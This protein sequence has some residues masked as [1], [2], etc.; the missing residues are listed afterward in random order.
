MP[1]GRKEKTVRF[2]EK[3]SILKKKYIVFLLIYF[4][5]FSLYFTSTTMSKYVT[6]EVITSNSLQVA[7]WDVDADSSSDKNIVLVSGDEVTNKQSYFIE[8]TSNSE[9]AAD[10]KI[11]ISNLKE[12]VVVSLDNGAY[13]TPIA[14]KAVLSNS[15]CSFNANDTNSIHNHKIMFK[16]N[17]G[18][19]SAEKDNLNVD[20]VFTQ[21]SLED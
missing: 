11:V 6:E 10:Y 14:G 20:I 18:A 7:K 9:V 5:F 2:K 13:I 4:M 19:P 15:N 17:E 8:V 21:K 16:A 3:Q 12:G 1:I